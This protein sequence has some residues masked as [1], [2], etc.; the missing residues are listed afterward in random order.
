MKRIAGL[1]S[2]EPDSGEF[3]L[4]QIESTLEAALLQGA[5]KRVGGNLSAAA[6]LLGITRSRL[7]YRLGQRGIPAATKD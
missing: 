2:G 6:R 7:V 4:D 3:S 5:I 1:L